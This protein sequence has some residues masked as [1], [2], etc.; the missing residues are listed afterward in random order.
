MHRETAPAVNLTKTQAEALRL[1]ASG[2]TTAQAAADL[3]ITER[4][5]KNRL[6][7]ASER[8]QTRSLAETIQIATEYKL[9]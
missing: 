7:T 2:R 9:L 4:A 5:L 3:G 1:M 6:K 8:L